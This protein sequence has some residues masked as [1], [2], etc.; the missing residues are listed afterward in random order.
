MRV[1]FGRFTIIMLFA[2]F[3]SQPRLLADT[4]PPLTNDSISQLVAWHVSDTE[5]VT[6]IRR[7][8]NTCRFDL[9][10][11][12]V[13][14]LKAKGVSGDIL[15]AMQKCQRPLPAVAG[16]AIP[17]SQSPSERSQSVVGATT[18][19]VHDRMRISAATART[20]SGTGPGMKALPVDQVV[21]SDGSFVKGQVLFLQCS[22]GG[23][24]PTPTSIQFQPSGIAGKAAISTSQVQSLALSD[25]A[26]RLSSA[27]ATSPIP[28]AVSTYL[29]LSPSDRTALA[30]SP[31]DLNLTTAL[32]AAC[33]A[34]DHY[35]NGDLTLTGS[36]GVGTQ[37][38][39][40]IGGGLAT[41][42]IL[43]PGIY[44]WEYQIARLDLE[45]KY[46]VAQKLGSPALKSQ[47]IYYG[48]S[49][50]S[51]YPSSRWSP[52]GIAR[53]YHN[54]SLG[55]GLGQIY[56]A[57]VAY[58]LGG[59]VLSGGLVG[60]AERL[61]A[62]SVP[63][64]SGGAR[65]YESYARVLGN[66]KITF[67]ES[68]DI[69]PSFQVAKAIQGRGVGGFVIPAWSRLQLIPKFGDDYLGNAPA[70]HRLNYSNTSLSLDF[71]IGRSQ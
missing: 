33:K 9:S 39:K 46:T 17:P 23:N 5:I 36:Y 50:Y 13:S 3:V 19:A 53:L 59:L 71:K 62:P 48:E 45:A 37:T 51:F 11:Q 35:W 34:V 57:G 15:V 44:S 40:Q 24:D 14:V 29:T 28:G 68:I 22:P 21:L 43:H 20:S 25:G 65:L 42:F 7:E 16:K 47:E 66:S 70:K 64:T 30:A 12:A 60:I 31:T 56:G 61:Y 58:S 10:P 49:T 6:A 63:F 8:S 2:L 69:F 41:S 32:T 18:D 67:F 4:A 38:Q 55:L 54:Y 26:I 27:A 1:G 52:Y